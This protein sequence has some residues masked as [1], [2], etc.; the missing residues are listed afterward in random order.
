MIIA[1][2]FTWNLLVLGAIRGLI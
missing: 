2:F 1:S